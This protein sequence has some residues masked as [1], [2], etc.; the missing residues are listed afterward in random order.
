M[1]AQAFNLDSSVERARV[2][3]WRRGGATTRNAS[4]FKEE[5]HPQTR[6]QL[7]NR[8]R[9]AL[10]KEV[11]SIEATNFNVHNDL[12]KITSG[13]LRNLGLWLWVCRCQGHGMVAGALRVIP[14]G[15]CACLIAHNVFV[16]WSGGWADAQG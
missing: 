1:P 10:T 5:Q 14:A 16:R 12:V 2:G 3:C 6:R 8:V 13:Q 4:A 9:S 15:G 11:N 7:L